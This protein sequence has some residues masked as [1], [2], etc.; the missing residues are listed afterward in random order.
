MLRTKRITAAS[1][2]TGLGAALSLLLAA[3]AARPLHAQTPEHAQVGGVLEEI[4]VSAQKREQNIQSVGISVTA[5]SG[6]Q[7]RE[8]GFDSAT[9]IA[10][11]VPSMQVYSFHPSYAAINLRGVSQNDFADHLEPPIAMYSDEAYVAHPGAMTAQTFDLERV[12]VLRGPQG[13]LFGRNAT[14]GLVHV[15]TRKPTRTPEGYFDLSYGN[16]DDIRAEGAVSGPLSETVA[17]RLSA[18]YNSRNGWFE[19][20]VGKDLMDANNYALRLQ[21]LFE[22]SEATS[23]LLKLHGSRNE[24][25]T[26]NAY[27]HTP[28]APNAQGLGRPIGPTELGVFPNIVLG[29]TFTTCP[30]CDALGYREPDNDWTTGSIDEPGSFDRDIYGATL[31]LRHDFG[32]ATLTSITDYLSI[33]KDFSGDIDGSPFPFFAFSTSQDSTQLSQE[34]RLD[35]QVDKLHWQTGLYYLD[36]DSSYGSSVDFDVSPYIG[37]PPGTVIAPNTADW[38]LDVRSWAVFGEVEYAFTD[39][40]AAI[41]GLRYTNDKKEDDYRLD[42]GL[43]TFVFDKQ[44]YPD[45]AEQEFENVSAKLE[46]D[47][48]PNDDWLYYLSY[49]RGHKAGNFAAPVFGVP[50]DPT[51]RS[52]VFPR[53]IPHDEEVLSSYETGFKGR[54]ADGR[55]RMNASAFYYDYDDY[56]V[57]FLQTL[58]QA[59]FNRDATVTGAELELTLAPM[60]GLEILLGVSSLFEAKVKDVPLPT[61]QI[62]DRR[63]PLSPDLTLNGLV[64]YEWPALGGALSVQADY[65]WS[66]HFYHTA[67]NEPVTYEPAFGV[68]N[69]R[70]GYRNGDASWQFALWVKNV[71]DEKYGAF[72]LD[73]G[74]LGMCGCAYGTPR[75]YGVTV[76]RNW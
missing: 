41:V 4:V 20:R 55:A 62:V 10:L 2:P 17:A 35:G 67:L 30:G 44:T 43:P 19:N 52:Q 1:V 58:A 32:G 65:K 59:I 6:D 74:A 14:G 38:D 24:D 45:L 72:R 37:L 12:E 23:A 54:F 63:L 25:E 9:D 51:F 56:Q 75:T 70:L 40:I 27:V 15:V 26:G 49:N 31:K 46:L 33:E 47:W 18:A 13:T 39:H 8:L 66:E 73:I 16:Y 21:L 50:A 69:A 11:Q 29:G 34:L 22:P 76:S 5:F 48:R 60:T 42:S 61:G 7:M 36:I 64:R 71:T 57:F 28:T 68:G 3:A 53:I